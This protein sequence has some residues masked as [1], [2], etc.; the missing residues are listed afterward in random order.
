MNCFHGLVFLNHPLLALR[1]I[2]GRPVGKSYL[3]S[4]PET[5]LYINESEAF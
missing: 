1:N 3:P 2:E 4:W 5:I